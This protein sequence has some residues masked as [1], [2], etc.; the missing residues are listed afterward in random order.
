MS[1]GPQ[2]RAT[3]DSIAELVGVSKATVSK[4]LNERPGVSEATRRRVREAFRQLGYMPTT[5]T[6]DPLGRRTV[7][8]LFDT[9]ANLYALRM[10][11]GLIAEAQREGFEVVPDVTSP[12]DPGPGALLRP[13]R[14]RQMREHGHQGL[15]VVTTQLSDEVTRT[16]AEIGL[17]VVAIDPPN[18]LDPAV[19]SVGSNNWSGGYQATE[20]LVSLG[21]RRIGFV[22]GSAAHAG[23]RERRGGYRAALEEAGIS[24]DPELVGESGMGAAGDDAARM[25]ELPDPPTAF[26]ASS[27]PGA[28]AVLRQVTEKGLRVPEDISIVGYDDTYTSLPLPI[29]LTT[30]HTPIVE[31]GRVAMATVVGMT[32][33]R[34]PVSS[35]LQLATSL[36]VRESSA[37]PPVR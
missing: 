4:V 5:R 24:E 34:P 30:V 17:P 6:P 21:H 35:H 36:V 27:D 12:L 37:P 2:E 22:G 7:V 33:G 14:V 1:R 18:A 29:L 15:L 32:Q 28:L 20:H 23:L 9:L 3:L 31:I 11:D 10:L 13:E 16:C 26:Y 8:A 25:L 19:A